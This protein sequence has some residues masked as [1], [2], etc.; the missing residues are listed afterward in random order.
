M[1]GQLL[2]EME[3]LADHAGLSFP[4]VVERM[5]SRGPRVN[6]S[7]VTRWREGRSLPRADDAV[8]WA[9]VCGGEVD[10]VAVLHARAEPAFEEWK[11]NSDRRRR[12]G[13]SSVADAAP[14]V[15]AGRAVSPAT[16]TVGQAGGLRWRW[17]VTVCAIAVLLVGVLVWFEVAAEHDLS[18]PAV[19]TAES[20]SWPQRPLPPITWTAPSGTRRQVPLMYKVPSGPDSTDVVVEA[21]GS[22]LQPFV[23]TAPRIDQV[24]AIIG[25]DSQRA[26]DRARHPIR[27]EVVE[28]GQAGTPPRLLGQGRAEVTQDNVNKDLPVTVD[29]TVTPGRLYVLRVVNEAD[30]D[31]IGIYMNRLRGNGRSVAYDADGCVIGGIL[32]FDAAGWVLSGFVSATS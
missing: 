7:D 1:V 5:S 23:A 10:H 2:R 17:V 28:P 30:V 11:K 25:I 29:V 16:D 31:P 12:S 6:K 22:V 26:D 20:C 32:P 3:R 21:G 4:K 24:A 14:K 15:S 18:S 8:L 9:K 13:G 19:F 27:F